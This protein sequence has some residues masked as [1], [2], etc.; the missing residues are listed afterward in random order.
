MHTYTHDNSGKYTYV[1]HCLVFLIPEGSECRNPPT[2]D[3]LSTHP[4]YLSVHQLWERKMMRGTYR[5]KDCEK[6]RG[7][8]KRV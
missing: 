7:T 6:E 3:L 4:Q 1:L 8:G 5:R 2:P